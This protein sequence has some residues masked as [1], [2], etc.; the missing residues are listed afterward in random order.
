MVTLTLVARSEAPRIGETLGTVRDLFTEVIVVDTDFSI[1]V[2]A[3]RIVCGSN[4]M[5]WS[6][7]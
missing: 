6:S 3:F 2:F 5:G 7:Q 4:A 1:F